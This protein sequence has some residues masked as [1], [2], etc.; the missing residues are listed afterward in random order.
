M[1][2]M[3]GFQTSLFPSLRC[4]PRAFF[5]QPVCIFLRPACYRANHKETP[6]TVANKGFPNF[7][8]VTKISPLPEQN[9][10]LRR[11]VYQRQIFKSDQF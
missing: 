9:D 3:P 6:P 7:A 8:I 2:S 1:H 4:S 11:F 5:L 10:D